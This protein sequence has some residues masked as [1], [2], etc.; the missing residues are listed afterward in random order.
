MGIVGQNDSIAN[1]ILYR[2]NLF[3]IKSFNIIYLNLFNILF[4]LISTFKKFFPK[5]LFILYPY[6]FGSTAEAL[7]L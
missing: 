4:H 1:I 5:K 2:V 6:S 7:S 3:F